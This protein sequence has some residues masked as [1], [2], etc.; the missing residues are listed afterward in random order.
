[1]DRLTRRRFLRALAA[2]GA[3]YA[4]GRTPGTVMAH[5]AG[6]DGFA[7]YK[8]LV[9]VFLFGGNDSWSMLVPRSNAEYG[10]YAA[11]RQNLAIAQDQLLPIEPLSH[12]GAAYGLHP[13]MPGLQSLFES[14]RCAVVAN[15]GPLI[16]P[17]TKRTVPATAPR[18]CPCNSSRTSASWINGT[19]WAAPNR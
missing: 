12:D 11:S 18:G 19:P 16:E 1:M 7:D 4:F 8:A 3:L 6:L 13:S 2:G 5:A 9:C 17:V 10:V 14:G 15:V